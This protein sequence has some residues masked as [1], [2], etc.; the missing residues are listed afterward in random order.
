MFNDV[1]I[2]EAKTIE[3]YG[4]DSQ[5]L[6]SGSSRLVVVECLH[7]HA[8]I[9]NRAYRNAFR[10]H[11]CPIVNGNTKRC[12]KCGSWK[13]LSLFNKAP[14]QV[15]GV[16]K[17]CRACYNQEPSVKKCEKARR[18]RLQTALANDYQAYIRKR[19]YSI[20]NYCKTKHI[21]FDLDQQYLIDL[22]N[23]QNGL[24]YYTSLPMTGCSAT[25]GR[26]SHNIPS[27]D[28]RTPNL[29]YTKGNVVWC[30]LGVNAFKSTM[31]EIEF[32]EFVSKIKWRPVDTPHF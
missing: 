11:S 20:Q 4:Y 7:C 14:T 24:C 1:I 5:S 22:W 21:P 16:A 18:L 8:V 29:G 30:L 32:L 6:T 15:S 23:Q 10:K 17:L 3:K 12:Y 9:T 13:D 19:C 25:D 31:T 28:R 26:L 2:N 27:I